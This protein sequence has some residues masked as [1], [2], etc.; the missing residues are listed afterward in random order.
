MTHQAS[1]FGL[2]A[3]LSPPAVVEDVPSRAMVVCAHPDDAEIGAGATTARW[4]A[5]GCEI[6]FVVCTSGSGGS[7]DPGMT[8]ERLVLLRAEEQRESARALG[9]KEV[10]MLDH[11]DGGL[12]DTREFRGE[13]VRAIRKHRPHTVFTH[14]PYRMSGFHHRDHRITGIVTMD[15]VYPFARDHLHYPD[16]IEKEGL[17][18]HKVRQLLMWGADRPDVIVDVTETLERQIAALARHVSQVGGLAPRG[19]VGV[20]LRERAKGAAEGLPFRYGESFRRL[21]ARG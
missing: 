1:P 11:S 14:D 6:V 8:K 16:Q 3:E 18:P 10:V 5:Q 19:R 15:A 13:I 21:A 20:R 17:R 2:P 7:N 12:D 4:T 9:V